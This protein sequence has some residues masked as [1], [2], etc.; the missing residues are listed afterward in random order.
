[1]I[2]PRKLRPHRR[3]ILIMETDMAT[4]ETTH[5]MCDDTW[6]TDEQIDA[7]L[8]QIR[9]ALERAESLGKPLGWSLDEPA[10]DTVARIKRQWKS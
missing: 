10:A 3:G 4:T 8:R 5:H 6:M 1:M 9:S 7:R 2:F